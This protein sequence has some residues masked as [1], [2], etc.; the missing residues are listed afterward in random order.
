MSKIRLLHVVENL[1]KGAVE[2][3]LVQTFLESRAKRP[4]WQWTF[5]CVL[6]VKGRHDEQVRAAGGEIIYAE[7][8]LSDKLGFLRHFRLVVQ[9]GGYDA[10]HMHHD[11]MN[12]F[13]LLALFGLRRP[14]II[15]Q[16]HNNDEIIPVGS[17]ALRKLLLPFFRRICLTYAN[18]IVGISRFVLQHF[19][20]G[21]R[22]DMPRQHVLYYG[23]RMDRFEQDVDVEYEKASLQI[24]FESKIL[25]Y[26]G[27]VNREKNPLF[28]L[29]VLKG[30]RQRGVDAYAVFVGE[31]ELSAALREKTEALGLLAFVRI[32]GWSDR[33]VALM[34]SA[35]VFLF[36]RL[37][38]P[39]EGLGL[40]V[41][42]SQCAG[43][44]MVTTDGIV[45]DAIVIPELVVR[46]ELVVEEWLDET[47]SVLRRGTSI[48]SRDALHLMKDSPFSL[49]KA[50][51]CL[52]TLYEKGF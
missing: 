27:R 12:G 21:H 9:K 44:P 17:A 51:D 29:D 3:W 23:I 42:E 10:I 18:D 38:E 13:Y 46:R 14:R 41:V 31:G 52:I 39:R 32:L 1:D 24:P 19:V 45:D 4:E 28:V 7:V 47:E 11:F 30:L 49:P 50:T 2:N 35:S 37:R 5:Y 20:K 26:I 43:L 34:K 15:L 40:V 25:L 16:V 48:H 22:G 8:P 6:G 33:V 36:P